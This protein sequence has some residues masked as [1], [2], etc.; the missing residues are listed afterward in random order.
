MTINNYFLFLFSS[1]SEFFVGISN[2][3]NELGA[4]AIA[5]AFPEFPCVPIKV[6]RFILMISADSSLSFTTY[7]L[8]CTVLSFVYQV[9]DEYDYPL[10]ILS[11]DSHKGLIQVSVRS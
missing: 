1:G 6:R 4:K 2:F 11:L 10:E 7:L 9:E 3:T 8:S 5:A